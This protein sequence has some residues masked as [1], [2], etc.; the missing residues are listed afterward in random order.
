MLHG[1]RLDRV[2][3]AS[4]S[5]GLLTDGGELATAVLACRPRGFALLDAE[6]QERRLQSWGTLLAGLAGTAVRRLQWLERTLPAQGEDLVRWFHDERDPRL[7]PRGVPMVDSY[8]E[9]ISRASGVTHEHEVLLAVQIAAG[10]DPG[11]RVELVAGQVQRLA[12]SLRGAEVD[13]LGV[14]TEGQLARALRLAFDPYARA[15]VAA[16]DLTSPAG[17]AACPAPWPAACHEAWDHVRIDGSLHATYWIAAWPQRSVPP[18]F[19]DPLL[20]EARSVRTVAVCLEPVAAARATRAAEA[21]VTRDYAERAVRARF[22]QLETA[23]ARE[24]QEAAARREQEL[25]VGHGEVRFSG[26]V[27][28]SGRDEEELA[29]RCAEIGE[30]AARARLE[31]RRMYGQQLDAFAFTLPLCRGLS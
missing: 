11:A 23:R 20:G 9:L 31:L 27:T 22:G 17:A 5:I 21:A 26:F 3:H 30:Q 2:E 10:R 12:A 14:L 24:A 6:A 16:R 15:D 18:G 13:V 8:L 4:G 1:L 7:P 29:A 28:V 25:A 19:L